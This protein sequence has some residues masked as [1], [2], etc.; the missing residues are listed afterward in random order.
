MSWTYI[1]R[2][3]S[4]P[5]D[6]FVTVTLRFNGEKIHD[7]TYFDTSLFRVARFNRRIKKLENKYDAKYTGSG[8]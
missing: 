6:T 1:V 2:S 3:I 5:S 7:W 8:R 4:G